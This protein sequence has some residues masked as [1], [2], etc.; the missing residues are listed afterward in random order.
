MI[1]HFERVREMERLFRLECKKKCPD[2]DENGLV[3]AYFHRF[4][5]ETRQ[6]AKWLVP[7]N[8]EIARQ[9]IENIGDNKNA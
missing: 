4:Y 6:Q 9:M 5:K 1:T 2:E 3:K 8:A 7:F